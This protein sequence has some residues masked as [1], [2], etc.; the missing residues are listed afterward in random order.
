MC[1]SSFFGRLSSVAMPPFCKVFLQTNKGFVDQSDYEELPVIGSDWWLVIPAYFIWFSSHVCDLKLLTCADIIFTG[2]RQISK[3]P[4]T[5]VSLKYR[6][7]EE[8]CIFCLTC[9]HPEL[10]EDHVLTSAC[11]KF[12]RTVTRNAVNKSVWRKKNALDFP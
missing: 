9:S 6:A 4:N 7:C 12:F 11:V 8:G 2:P 5:N 1:I 10:T 3:T